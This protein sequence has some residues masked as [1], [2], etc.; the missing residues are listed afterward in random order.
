MTTEQQQ[1]IIRLAGNNSPL[2]DYS[3]D[4][5]RALIDEARQAKQDRDEWKA[6]A[7]R[8]YE[9]RVYDSPDAYNARINEA[10]RHLREQEDAGIRA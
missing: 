9:R 6:E 1:E 4:A 8:Q 5:L 7:R 2:S 3:R 10:V